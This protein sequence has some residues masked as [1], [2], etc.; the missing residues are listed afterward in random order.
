MAC[1][2]DAQNQPWL[3]FFWNI[4]NYSYYR[5]KEGEHICS[6]TFEVESIEN[7]EWYFYLYPQSSSDENYISYEL[8]GSLSEETREVIPVEFELAILTEDGSVLEIKEREGTSYRSGRPGYLEAFALSKE[9]IKRE[10]FLSND[11]L[12]TRCRLWRTD[13]KAAAS[14][15]FL[16]RTAMKVVRWNFLRNV[17]EFSSLEYDEIAINLSEKLSPFSKRS[18]R[19]EV[20]KEDKLMIHIECSLLSVTFFT[21]QLFI[22]DRKRRETDCGKREIW[23]DEKKKEA[24]YTL[25]FTKTYL[26]KNKDLFLEDDSLSL[27]CEISL[28]DGQYPSQEFK[29]LDSGS[30]SP[31]INDLVIPNSYVSDAEV[32]QSKSMPGLK[33]DFECLY[34][35]GTLS[36]VKLRTASETFQAHKSILSARSPVFL[37][38]FT[39]DMKESLQDYVD[40]S[41]LEDDTVRR[42]L[43]YLYTD[44]LKDLQWENALKLYAAADKYQIVTLKVKCCY[45]L[46]RNLCSRN[47]C[48]LLCLADL[49]GDGEL[50][51]A[52]QD[53][54]LAH[55]ENVFSSDEWAHF[56]KINGNLAAETMML[57]WKRK[58]EQ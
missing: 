11:T 22:R 49:H 15:T 56:F 33:E 32:L 45:F 17:S 31:F 26:T 48:D 58:P 30:I 19:M 7:S 6:P 4:E 57:K 41:D 13:G 40:V 25:P 35:K 18:L 46:K 53:Y 9:M 51:K 52:A 3:T 10:A 2:A 14:L 47:V 1:N 20:N 8:Y 21:V 44:T 55:E 54:I 38:M 42:M 50:K 34:S 29:K 28:H 39:S 23:P 36:D 12:R 24:V 43:L 5:K 16:G 37:A 27:F